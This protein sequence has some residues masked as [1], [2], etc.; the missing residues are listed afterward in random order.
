MKKLV[1]LI[2]SILV[3]NGFSQIKPND[4]QNY[5]GF[6]A[7]LIDL[8]PFE[9]SY[10]H[11]NSK[12]VSF[13]LR[14]GFGSGIKNAV[15]ANYSYNYNSYY[16]NLNNNFTFEQSFSAIF[17]KTGIIFSKLKKPNYTFYHIVNYS[18]ANCTDKI[19]INN[20]DKLYGS[21]IVEYREKNINHAL[22][23]EGNIQ[24]KLLPNL[25]YG[26]GYILG[27]KLN[28]KIPFTSV[29][30]GIEKGSTY[31]PSQGVGYNVYLNFSLSLMYKL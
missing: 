15:N 4:N 27:F 9:F 12:G 19:I 13:T 22:E 17:F 26:L 25:D 30:P 20:N 21:Y 28:P 8:M 1:T 5:V 29:L 2:F 11:D 14:G 24:F 7:R 10:I 6:Q 31:S 16:N 18:Y 3:L 23:Y